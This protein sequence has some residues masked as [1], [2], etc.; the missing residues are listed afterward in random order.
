MTVETRTSLDWDRWRFGLTTKADVKH[1]TKL[2]NFVAQLCCTTK[3]PVWLCK[4]PN[5]WRVAQLICQI[6]TISILRQFL[7]LSLSC[8]WSVVCLHVNCCKL[9]RSLLFLLRFLT[10][11]W[12]LWYRDKA[13]NEALLIISSSVSLEA[14]FVG[15]LFANGKLTVA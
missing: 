14:M 10:F 12:R 8:D 1:A 4:L 9:K 7:A 11:T 6:E 3:L 5:F 15:R 13:I 2:S